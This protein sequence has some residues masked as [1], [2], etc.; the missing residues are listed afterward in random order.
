MRPAPS[1]PIH[2]GNSEAGRDD[3]STRVADGPSLKK[4]AAPRFRKATFEDYGQ[5]A[6][7]ES[8]YGIRARSYEEWTHLWINNPAYQELRDWPIGWVFENDCNEIVGHIAN[9]PLSYEFAGRRLLAASS[10][11]L[12]VDPRYRIYAFRLLGEFL[13]QTNVDLFVNT[14]ANA[15]T[16]K[17]HE[18]F[19]IPKVP[20]G[21]WDQ[22]AFWITNY[23]GFLPIALASKRVPFAR[24]LGTPLS[25]VM[26]LRKKFSSS[27]FKVTRNEFEFSPCEDFDNRF[28]AFWETL[29]QSRP[30]SLLAT[31]S[32]GVLA[33]HFKY[34]LAGKRLWIIT[35]TGSST[36]G[37]SSRMVAY[38]VF[39][40]SDNRRLGL[41]A[42]R[43]ID[44]QVLSER[45]DLLLP[46]LDW[47]VQRCEREG[48]HMMEAF[49][50]A[51]DK[52]A[53]IAR[54]APYKRRLSSWLYFYKANDN[55]LAERLKD[56]SVWDPSCFDGD[57]SL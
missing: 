26:R 3:L 18:A 54:A 49:G 39:A 45:N 1:I 51:P 35:A 16:C 14:T 32:R 31:R 22:T 53:V 13:G 11:D 6:T 12:V 33:W 2:S 42:V 38:A 17:A 48:I 10:G 4:L 40:R 41:K 34:A 43:L 5:I 36:V 28:E 46:I 37:A 30:S 52:Q 44:F 7:L 56:P 50:F 24:G 15:N 21:A 25:A 27:R 19:R 9:F 57:S 29:R 55:Q 23:S 47:A 8:H 20:V